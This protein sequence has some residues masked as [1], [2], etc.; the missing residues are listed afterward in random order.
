VIARAA[1]H[2]APRRHPGTQTGS[3]GSVV[4]LWAAVHVAPRS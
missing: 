2:V 3:T 4:I 1:V